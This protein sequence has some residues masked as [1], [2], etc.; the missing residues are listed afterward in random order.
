MKI[1][2]NGSN[3]FPFPLFVL[4]KSCTILNSLKARQL[5]RRDAIKRGI[6]IV[7]PRSDRRMNK[8]RNRARCEKMMN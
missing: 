8:S 5:I 2:E 6:A 3:M 1:L 4:K 7:K